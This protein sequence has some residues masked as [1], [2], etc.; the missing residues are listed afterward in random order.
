MTVGL[1]FFA[2]QSS[3]P[4]MTPITDLSAIDTPNPSVDL[5]L[6]GDREWMQVPAALQP[7]GVATRTLAGDWNDDHRLDAVVLIEGQLFVVV[8]PGEARGGALIPTVGSI[9]DFD[10]L[11]GGGP[12]GQDALIAVGSAGL[13]MHYFHNVLASFIEVNLESSDWLFARSVRVLERPLLAADIYVG[14]GATPTDVIGYL[15]AQDF[16]TPL[17]SHSAPIDQLEVLE[18]AGDSEEEFVVMSNEE[19]TVYDVR[20]LQYAQFTAPGE[21]SVALAIFQRSLE[22][23]DRIAW[24][25]SEGGT[26]SFTLRLFADGIVEPPLDLGSLQLS[27]MAAGELNGDGSDELFLSHRT[28]QHQVILRSQALM[29]DLFSPSFDSEE[30]VILTALPALSELL[31]EF[32]IG[33]V[34]GS[35]GGPNGAGGLPGAYNSV[36]LGGLPGGVS[37]SPGGGGSG[38]TSGVTVE[39]GRLNQSNQVVPPTTDLINPFLRNTATPAFG[40]FDNDGD[41]DILFPVSNSGD[42]V[43]QRNGLIDHRQQ[44]P[45]V[46]SSQLNSAGPD[47]YRL[48]VTISKPTAVS[49]DATHVEL[50]VWRSPGLGDS[51]DYELDSYKT[52]AIEE[53]WPMTVSFIM[54]E[55]IL[56]F[57]DLY[58][59]QLRLVERTPD[60]EVILLRAFP[61]MTATFASSRPVFEALFAAAK[62]RGGG[63]TT[64]K[65]GPVFVGGIAPRPNLDPFAPGAMPLAPGGGQV[66]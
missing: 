11:P 23:Y 60:T 25:T 16:S 32:P 63:V 54:D 24:A 10:F 8:A 59:M 48:D 13:T 52:Y 38:G 6:S 30:F 27:S 17:L 47:A 31:D 36:P 50:A 45:R 12:D 9:A 21:S 29:G 5:Q 64:P 1:L 35:G 37:T 51:T 61:V 7:N 19:A 44:W 42:L 57:H 2:L 39:S 15:P 4:P 41:L 18:W 20:A 43:F 40:D 55:P 26:A 66:Q 53:G 49:P 3:L 28:S 46:A 33:N 65:T 58:H 62:I 14:V 22:P 34:P 56:P